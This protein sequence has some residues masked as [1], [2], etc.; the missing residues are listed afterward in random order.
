VTSQSW[1]GFCWFIPSASLSLQLAVSKVDGAHK[2]KR[3]SSLLH[4]FTNLTRIL[5]FA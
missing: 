2:G 5:A 4:A 1:R 3:K